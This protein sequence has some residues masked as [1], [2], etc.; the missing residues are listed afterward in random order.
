MSYPESIS[1]YPRVIVR[2][3]AIPFVV[4]MLKELPEGFPEDILEV[5]FPTPDALPY[6]NMDDDVQV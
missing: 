5:D 3:D 2:P 6:T 1:L 4:Q